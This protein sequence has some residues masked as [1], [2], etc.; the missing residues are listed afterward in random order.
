MWPTATAHEEMLCITQVF[1]AADRKERQHRRHQPQ[2]SAPVAVP[3]S[4]FAQ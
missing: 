4:S 1:R 3:Q 2:K